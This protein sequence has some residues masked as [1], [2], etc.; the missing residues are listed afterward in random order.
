[1]VAESADGGHRVCL[2]RVDEARE[3]AE[4][5]CG[6]TGPNR[7]VTKALLA[8]AKWHVED[9]E[10]EARTR[11]TLLPGT[12]LTVG[13]ARRRLVGWHQAQE[14][15][16]AEAREVLSLAEALLRLVDSEDPH[17]FRA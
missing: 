16:T 6:W 8:D 14:G 5:G 2:A 1:M 15:L 17:G 4:C 13:D 10:G 7:R 9:E 11:Q 3:R 12:E